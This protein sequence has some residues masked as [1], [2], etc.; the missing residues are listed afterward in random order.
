MYIE[1]KWRWDGSENIDRSWM[2]LRQK[3]DKSRFKQDGSMMHTSS[4][5]QE[6]IEGEQKQ[7]NVKERRRMEMGMVKM[8]ERGTVMD[9]RI[10]KMKYKVRKMI[11][12]EKNPIY[13]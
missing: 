3:W 1:V 8:E 4:T 7:G 6:G 11:T 5:K 10:W 2:E 9:V 12:F 13:S